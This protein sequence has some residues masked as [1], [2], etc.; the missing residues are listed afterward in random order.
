MRTPEP[1]FEVT[2]VGVSTTVSAEHAAGGYA[3]RV[4]AL[5][6]KQVGQLPWDPA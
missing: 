4:T 3:V 2:E 6:L 1:V 5:A